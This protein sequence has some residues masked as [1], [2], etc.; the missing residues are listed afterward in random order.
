[1]AYTSVIPVRRLDWAVKYVMNK[2]K[3]TAVSL[4]DALDYAANRDKTEQSCFESSYAC[5]LETAFADMRQ[6]KERWH[7]SGGVQGYHLVQSFAAGEV[8]PELAHQIA[9][10]LADRVLGG[11]YEYVIGTHLNTG[12]IHSHIVWNSVSGVDGKK[13]RSNYKSYVTEIRAVSDE[14]CRKYKLSIIDTENSNHVAKP[15][16]EWLAEK[17]NQPTWRTAIRQDVDEAIQQSLTWRQFLTVLDRK[18]YEVR[19]G[20][21][22]PILRPPGKERFVRFKTLGKRYTPE[23]I[24]TLI[25]YPRSY[26]PYVENPPTIQHGRLHSG[27]KP[28]RKL[29]GLRALYYRYLYELGALPRKPSRPSYAVRQDAYKLDQRIRQME[30]LSK[31]NIDTLEQLETHRQALQTEIRQLLTKR[32]QLPKT[33]DVQSQHESVNTA[34]KQLR[35]EERLCRKIAEHSLEVQQHLTEAHRDRAEQQKQEQE[36]ARDRRPN[37]DLTL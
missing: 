27:K 26:R 30:F 37:I 23:A 35:Q 2:E 3:T 1:M 5:T 15:Y 13:Y 18:G 7:K 6:T 12:H 31:H 21:K 24:Q 14:L 11:R 22:Y 29:T 4:Q 19:M 32:K 20:R 8:S 34:L 17:N 25:L 10:E 28:H 36:H 9:K 16:A 33:D